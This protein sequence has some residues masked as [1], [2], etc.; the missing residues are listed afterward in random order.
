MVTE[1][2]FE[3]SYLRCVISH[4]VFSLLYRAYCFNYLLN[5]PTH[6]HTIYT[7]KKL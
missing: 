5:I 1:S 6:A 2:P 4:S 3:T 7:F